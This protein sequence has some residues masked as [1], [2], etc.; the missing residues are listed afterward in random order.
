MG[1]MTPDNYSGYD[2]NVKVACR[3]LNILTTGLT[4]QTC[5]TSMENKSVVVVWSERFCK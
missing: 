3:S 5:R 1:V 4:Y 2:K